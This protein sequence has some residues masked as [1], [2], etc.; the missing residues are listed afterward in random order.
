M[1]GIVDLTCF[2]DKH[3][4]ESCC[5]PPESQDKGNVPNTATA[6][7]ADSGHKKG[8]LMVVSEIAWLSE[9]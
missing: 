9:S 7:L 3:D 2:K 4:S 6:T 8:I 1:L 5:F